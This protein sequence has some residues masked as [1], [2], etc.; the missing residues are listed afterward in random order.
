M[1][2]LQS[3]LLGLI[4]GFTEFLPVSS[5]GHLVLVQKILKTHFSGMTMEIATHMG[6]LF[7]ILL[8]YR[9]RFLLLFKHKQV[10]SV[11]SRV[12]V[13]V[14][15]AIFVGLLFKDQITGLFKNSNFVAGCFLVTAG[16]LLLGLR[17]K[18]QEHSLVSDVECNA[19]LAKTSFW[20]ILVVG[21]FQCLALFPGV[22]RSGTTISMARV[23]KMT[24]QVSVYLSFFMAIPLI[25]GACTLEVV[26]LIKTQGSLSL[27]P[28][29]VGMAAAFISGFFALKLVE[30]WVQNEKL[31]RFA[32]YLILVSAI[33]FYLGN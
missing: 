27:G 16:F 6:T 18:N 5:S 22:S 17:T 23:F 30:K 10:L 3:I 13:G 24:P 33:M 8:W 19:E 9:K 2:F 12:L 28:L 31:F 11:G 21:V 29:L 25:L 32:P 4:Q 15:P 7:T 1:E 14:L 20:K 26:D